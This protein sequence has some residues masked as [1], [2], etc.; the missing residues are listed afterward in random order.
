MTCSDWHSIT[1]SQIYTLSV[2]TGSSNMWSRRRSSPNLLL[3]SFTEFLVVK[4]AAYVNSR[5]LLAVGTRNPI[6]LLVQT[7]ETAIGWCSHAMSCPDLFDGRRMGIV[8]HLTQCAMGWSCLPGCPHVRTRPLTRL[9]WTSCCW[10]LPRIRR[11]LWI[12]RAGRQHYA[13]VL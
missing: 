2:L 3:E 7:V 4:L 9:I 13:V 10:R 6:V 11:T 5:S 8:A 12:S 1:S